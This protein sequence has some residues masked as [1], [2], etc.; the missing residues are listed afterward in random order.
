MIAAALQIF[1]FI[2]M[3]ASVP[4]WAAGRDEKI[5]SDHPSVTWGHAAHGLFTRGRSIGVVITLSNYMGEQQGGY[6]ELR[7]ARNDGEKMIKFLL[8]EAGFD[9]VYVLTEEKVTKE[10]I[11][12]LMIDEV[13]Q[14][15]TANDRFLFYWSGHGDQLTAGSNKFGFLPLLFSKRNEFGGMVSMDDITRWN[16]YLVA[17]HG[18]FLLDSCLSGLAGAEVKSA[19]DDRLER[20]AQPARHLIT[21]GQAGE[22]VISGER[23]TG[24]LFTDSFIRG[25]TGEAQTRD[26]IISLWSLLDYV[27]DRVT[28]EKRIV[29]WQKSLSPQLRLLSAGPG[30]FF[31]TTRSQRLSPGPPPPGP[32]GQQS[33]MEIEEKLRESA[34]KLARQS[35]VDDGALAIVREGILSF[36]DRPAGGQPC[37]GCPEFVIVPAGSFVMGS[38]TGKSDERPPHRVTIG[39]AFGV[40]KFPVTRGEFAAFVKET[41]YKSEGGCAGFNG[42]NWIMRTDLSWSSPGFDQNDRHPVVCINSNDVTSFLAWLSRKTRRLYRLLTE[43]EWEYMARAETTAGYFFGDNSD[44]LCRYGNGADLTAKQSFPNIEGVNCRDGYVFTAPVDSFKPNTWGIH[45]VHGNVR[46]R[47]ADCYNSSYKGAPSDA[48]AWL[49][50]DCDR[51]VLR[52]GSWSSDPMELRSASRDRGAPKELRYDNYGFRI[53]RDL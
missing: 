41:G 32:S 44:E 7:T 23:W 13:R 22:N 25:A 8:E 9:I 24:S 43:A 26:D 48:S 1:C 5:I 19:R 12:R 11:D 38:D 18:L 4:C 33:K 35:L 36:R 53:A 17:Q 28:I 46:Q 15:V 3:I 10:R 42:S 29:G 50:G 2:F 14:E 40:G 27:Q 45:D 31:F 49:A 51:N 30:A 21:A 39:K 16:N 6:R 47:V 34:V 20:L 52:G 37:S